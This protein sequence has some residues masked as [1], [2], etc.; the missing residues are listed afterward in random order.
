MVVGVS[1]DIAITV[2]IGTSKE[3]VYSL[4]KC[5]FSKACFRFMDMHMISCIVGSQVR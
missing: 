3:C 1:F 2:L 4:W 5:H